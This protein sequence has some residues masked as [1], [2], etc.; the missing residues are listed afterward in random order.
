M[1]PRISLNQ[2]EHQ[3]PWLALLSVLLL[4]ALAGALDLWFG[5]NLSL[6]VLGM[7]PVMIAAWLLG[8]RLAVALA[9]FVGAISLYGDSLAHP[10]GLLQAENISSISARLAVLIT[11]ALLTGALRLTVW[12]GRELARTDSLTG[13]ENRISFCERADAEI[14]RSRRTQ[15]AVTLAFVDCDGFKAVNDRHGHL[16]GDSLLRT[17]ADTLQ[18]N[19][20]NYDVVARLGGDEFLLLLPETDPQTA[21]AVVDRVQKSLRTTM[22]QNGWPVTFSIGAATFLHPPDSVDEMIHAADKLMYAVKSAGKNGVKYQTNRER[23][24]R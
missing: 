19:T 5:D 17:V 13:L 8:T 16:A 9:V 4:C 20:R 18:A 7:F 12:H 24:D 10:G 15:H 14:N 11:V 6:W 21:Q 1:Q 2:F 23:R 3:P 22:E